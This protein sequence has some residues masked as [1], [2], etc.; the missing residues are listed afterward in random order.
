[1]LFL[2]LEGR[3]GKLESPREDGESQASSSN[4]RGRGARGRT[5]DQTG[6]QRKYTKREG[7]KKKKEAVKAW[8]WLEDLVKSTRRQRVRAL[9]PK[10]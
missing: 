2:Y 4:K 8:H 10:K 9:K 7:A 1:M 3:D 6:V 5:R